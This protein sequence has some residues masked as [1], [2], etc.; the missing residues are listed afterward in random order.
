MHTTIGYNHNYYRIQ[1]CL[2][3][4]IDSPSIEEKFK[5]YDKALEP[6]LE[7]ISKLEEPIENALESSKKIPQ[8]HYNAL[9]LALG[10]YVVEKERCTLE[11]VMLS[12]GR[13]YN[14]ALEFIKRLN[15]SLEDY[16]RAIIFAYKEQEH[17]A[18]LATQSK[19]CFSKS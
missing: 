2:M 7:V 12:K 19:G 9:I 5:A 3:D 18:N 6:I 4:T 15:L 10:D 17:K 14:S 13:Y 8:K 11:A 1:R 16:H